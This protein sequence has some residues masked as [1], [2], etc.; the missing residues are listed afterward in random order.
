MLFNIKNIINIK[1]NMTSVIVAPT[2]PSLKLATNLSQFNSDFVFLY[3][4]TKN[5]VIKNSHFIRIIYSSPLFTLNGIFIKLNINC[6]SIEHHYSKYKCSYDANYYKDV[7][8]TIAQIERD[9]LSKC[10]I[11]DKTPQHKIYEQL[12]SGYIKVFSDN[13]TKPSNNFILKISGIWETESQYG[14]TYKFIV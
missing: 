9:V 7:I 11:V 13:L 1:R 2:M 3:E 10:K 6:Y 12:T 14:L 8:T 4:P 5:V